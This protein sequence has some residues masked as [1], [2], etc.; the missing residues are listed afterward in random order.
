MLQGLVLRSIDAT[1]PNCQGGID[2]DRGD[3]AVSVLADTLAAS[4]TQ[5]ARVF[6][7]GTGKTPAEL[8]SYEDFWRFVLANYHSGAGCLY[9]A[10][11]LTGYPTSWP[12]I[13]TNL[14]GYCTSGREYVRRIEENLK[15]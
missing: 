11:Q 12:A 2:P 13:S 9:Q 14:T 5:G 8:L 10:L 3:Q 6:R 15:P 7:M 1:C 4:C